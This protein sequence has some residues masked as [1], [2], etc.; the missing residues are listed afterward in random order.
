MADQENTVVQP[1]PSAPPPRLCF[2]RRQIFTD[3]LEVTP[4]NVAEILSKV[5]TIH[6]RNRSDIQ[7][8]YD[9]Y[10][11]RQ[12]ILGREKD[13]R[14]EINNRVVVNRA[15]EI[16]SFKTSYLLGEPIQYVSSV[17][18][19]GSDVVNRL[20]RLNEYMRLEGKA[21]KDMELANWMHICGVAYRLVLPDSLASD[22]QDSPF[23][24]YTL[25]PRD[26]FVIR[27]SGVSRHVIAGVHIVHKLEE[28]DIL[29]V[30][31][32]KYY[33]EIANDFAGAVPPA[34]KVSRVT[35]PVVPIIE[36]WHN[37]SRMGAFE[38]VLSQ[39]NEINILESN[40]VDAIEQQVQAIT[41]FENCDVDDADYAQMRKSGAIRITSPNGLSAKV[42]TVNNELQQDGVQKAVDD[43][44][45][46]ILD[47]CGMPSTQNGGA[48]TSDT[49]S[50]VIYRDGW[51]QAESRAK[52]TE[53]YF[54]AAEQQLLRVVLHICRT[55]HDLDI[56]I[57]EVVLQFTRRNYADLLTKS[58]VLTT[59]LS[60]N[61]I[62]PKLA[63]ET[64]GLFI[65]S[66][67]AYQQSLPYIEK[68]AQAAAE[69][70]DPDQVDEGGSRSGQ[71][72]ANGEA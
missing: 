63:F 30:Y 14:P 52:E 12:D 68:A 57:S 37:Q 51:A 34:V 36:Y 48:S 10:K 54:K 61:K 72:G 47:I 71:P 2:G 33:M 4:D 40:R 22:P 55:T 49:G 42:Y 29:C 21:G 50:A 28:P 39:L 38:V 16:V 64:C 6:N 41:V 53:G 58:Q 69:P 20:S 23:N 3:K 5:L 32:P 56:S 43:L 46:S 24:I 27:Y 26:T 11:G 18:G 31:T 35:Y 44:Y 15:N 19:S 66:E 25:D 17:A 9:V 60:S 7:Y 45:A 59:M 70:N 1:N 8:L 65:D 13:I 67:A 62:A